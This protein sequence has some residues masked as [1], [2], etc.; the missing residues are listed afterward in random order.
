MSEHPEQTEPQT[1]EELAHLRH[2]RFGR[3]PGRVRPEE[4]VESEETDPVHE[5]P[6]EPMVRREWG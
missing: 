1:D 3:L 4:L 6:G 2:T 5:E